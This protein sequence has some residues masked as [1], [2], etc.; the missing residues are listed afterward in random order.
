MADSPEVR[1]LARRLFDKQ[2]E[3]LTQVPEDQRD[4][5][6]LL[7]FLSVEA[8]LELMKLVMTTGNTSLANQ[9]VDELEEIM[10]QSLPKVSVNVRL[11]TPL[12]SQEES[13]LK[14]VIETETGKEVILNT[15]ID[16]KLLGGMVL[17]YDGKVVD[18]T[19]N[20]HLTNLKQHLLG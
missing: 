5:L 18:L 13:K 6:R 11:A 12:T 2:I 14:Q 8:S 16:K 7:V 15:S 20:E 17:E 9:V 10:R 4:H 19:V 3:L 1:A